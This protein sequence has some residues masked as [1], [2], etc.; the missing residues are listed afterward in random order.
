MATV[1]IASQD[2]A[3]S[4]EEGEGGRFRGSN[5]GRLDI[6]ETVAGVDAREVFGD[7]GERWVDVGDA[8]VAAGEIA[9][10][11][12]AGVTAAAATAQ[13]AAAPAA[14]I[15][16]G[17][18]A[19]AARERARW[20]ITAAAV[21]LQKPSLTVGEPASAAPAAFAIAAVARGTCGGHG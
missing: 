18:S 17:T 7:G 14:A 1:A 9:A 13:G 11:G 2:E 19:A 8:A 15:A 3:G 4:T 12:A 21:I 6:D 16:A 10:A 20:P 5:G